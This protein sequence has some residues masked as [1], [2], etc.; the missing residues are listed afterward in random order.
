MLWRCQ[1]ESPLETKST[2]M[3]RAPET[4]FYN[5]VSD[6][7]N[8]KHQHTHFPQ[9]KTPLPFITGTKCCVLFTL[10][11][12]DLFAFLPDDPWEVWRY[13]QMV[14]Q[15]LGGKAWISVSDTNNSA[16]QTRFINRI[17]SIFCYIACFKYE[18]GGRPFFSGC[19]AC[20][21]G[22]AMHTKKVLTFEEAAAVAAS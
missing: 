10:A 1:A 4:L 16:G 6:L 17:S 18:K 22:N 20:F 19:H 11:S 9:S 2:N 8:R 21:K 13:R 3:Q 15:C 12:S 14:N 7:T 5:S